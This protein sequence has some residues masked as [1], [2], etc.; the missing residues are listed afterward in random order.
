MT[1]TTLS[2]RQT[3]RLRLPVFVVALWLALATALLS[4]LI[5]GGLPRTTALG[6]AFHP[7]TTAVALQ[8]TRAQPRVTDETM[9]RDDGPA[10][11]Q[12]GG[13]AVTRTPP[14]VTVPTI[15]QTD[16]ALLAPAAPI[17]TF[18]AVVDGSPRAPPLN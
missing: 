16:N 12:G 13:I 11:G 15:P 7:S 9:R 8:P 5:P 14:S 4:S 10:S 3:A 1:L 2:Q 18:H 17:L 6:S